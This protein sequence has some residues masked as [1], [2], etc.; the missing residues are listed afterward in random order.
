MDSVFKCR[1]S[2]YECICCEE[3]GKGRNGINT[4]E[5]YSRKFPQIVEKLYSCAVHYFFMMQDAIQHVHTLAIY[6]QQTNCN[7]DND[8]ESTAVYIHLE[9]DMEMWIKSI[10]TMTFKSD[11]YLCFH[12]GSSNQL[13][14][15]LVKNKIN[16]KCFEERSYLQHAGKFLFCTD[17]Q[18]TCTH[19]GASRVSF[20]KEMGK[21]L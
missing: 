17:Y 12:F 19:N 8:C 7:H 5:L 11:I 20:D 2:R 9:R 16:K 14:F 1:L 18:Q 21:G 10:K 15:I 13:T 3:T 6:F 4:T